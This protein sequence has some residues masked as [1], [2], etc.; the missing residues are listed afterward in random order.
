MTLSVGW[1]SLPPWVSCECCAWECQLV[2]AVTLIV[3][4]VLKMVRPYVGLAYIV[5][6]LQ[7]ASYIAL[8]RDLQ[9]ADGSQLISVV[10]L[11]LLPKMSGL[12][13]ACLSHTLLK[14][15]ANR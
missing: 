14:L 3:V 11:Y 8:C 2:W 9:V 7:A 4:C 15:A 10:S 1:W 13:P 5:Y 6:V 12:D